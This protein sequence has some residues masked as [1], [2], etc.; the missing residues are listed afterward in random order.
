MRYLV[1]RFRSRIRGRWAVLGLLLLGIGAAAL[2][3]VRGGWHGGS[4]LEL[5]ALDQHGAFAEEVSIPAAWSGEAVSEW[6]AVTRFP[7]LLGIR[8][9]GTEATQPAR[10]EMSVPVRFRMSTSGREVLTSFHSPGEPLVRYTITRDLPP[11]APGVQPAFIGPDTIWLEPILPSLY[12][13]AAEDSVPVFVAAPP[14]DLET[15]SDV[16]I[17]YSLHGGELNGRQTGLLRVL[18][19]PGAMRVEAAPEVRVSTATVFQ[20]EIPGPELAGLAYGGHRYAACGEPEDPVELFATTWNTLGGGR[21]IVLNIGGRDR[22]Y[23]YDLTG[24]GF[25]DAERWDADGDGRFESMRAVRFPI[26]SFL[27]PIVHDATFDWSLIAELS[28]DSVTRLNPYRSA[29]LYRPRTSPEDTLPRL[30]RFGRQRQRPAGE[31]TP[32]GPPAP[33]GPRVLGEPLP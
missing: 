18:L 7:L 19:E 20:P 26:P 17:F 12:C 30:D 13:I 22:K 33:R 31:A 21:M 6:G 32:T 14:P 25:V 27:I 2:F 1:R 11:A 3:L 8:N 24:D 15:L 10:L 29:Q 23:L 9:L 4:Y 28:P 5:V 16:L